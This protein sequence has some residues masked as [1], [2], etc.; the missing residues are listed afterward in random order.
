[1]A[2]AA[3]ATKLIVGLRELL[4]AEPSFG[5][6]TLDNSNAFNSVSR[7]AVLRQLSDGSVPGE[8]RALARFAHATLG[9]QAPVFAGGGSGGAPLTQLLFR[10]SEGVQQGSVEGGDFFATAIQPALVA[11]D[12]ELAAVGAAARAGHGDVYV[13]GP[14]ALVAATERLA[15]FYILTTLSD[16]SFYIT[17]ALTSGQRGQHQLRGSE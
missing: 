4:D 3:G 7:A 9:P 6:L 8:I 13:V 10:S 5:I 17:T 16:G 2:V 11:L 12:A 1:V 14:P 15:P